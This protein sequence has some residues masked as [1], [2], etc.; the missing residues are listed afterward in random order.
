MSM[1]LELAWKLGAPCTRR[2]VQGMKLRQ[3]NSQEEQ[4][5]NHILQDQNRR[6]DTQVWVT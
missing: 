4:R 3:W 1:G 5:L 6:M 2:N